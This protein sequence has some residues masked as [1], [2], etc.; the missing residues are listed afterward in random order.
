MLGYIVRGGHYT[1][2]YIVQGTLYLRLYCLGRGLICGDRLFAL[3]SVLLCLL[4]SIKIA[5][6]FF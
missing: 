1:L 5:H 6:G 3:V 2:G 4:Y